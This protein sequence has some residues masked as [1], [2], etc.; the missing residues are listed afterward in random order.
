MN[1]YFKFTLRQGQAVWDIFCSLTIITIDKQSFVICIDNNTNL[2]NDRMNWV[3]DF[4][5]GKHHVNL[6]NNKLSR[7]TFI[8]NNEVLAKAQFNPSTYMQNSYGY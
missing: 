5:V 2:L 8:H 4:R 7:G 3:N 6:Y 1:T